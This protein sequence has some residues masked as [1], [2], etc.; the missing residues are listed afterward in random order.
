MW[1]P[2]SHIKIRSNCQHGHEDL[3]LTSN[4]VCDFRVDITLSDEI[5]V[6]V[7]W[8]SVTEVSYVSI[9]YTAAVSG[10]GGIPLDVD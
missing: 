4:F 2:H 3:V 9:V 6:V 5:W 7:G 1:R 8:H 10:L